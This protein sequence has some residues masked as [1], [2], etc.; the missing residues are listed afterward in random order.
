[1]ISK[2]ARLLDLLADGELDG[3][4][5][6]D[7]YLQKH[8]RRLAFRTIYRALD[9]M[10]EDGLA[11]SRMSARP[12]D[13]GTRSKHYASVERMFVPNDQA[14]YQV[15]C[16]LCEKRDRAYIR[17]FP[18]DLP[19]PNTTE[20]VWCQRLERDGQTEWRGSCSGCGRGFLLT[21]RPLAHSVES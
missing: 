10:V 16:H 2:Q 8:G 5:I 14:G 6:R 4:E 15:F 20:M 13:W 21:L 7:A 1:M 19:A 9:C 12:N 11:V 18:H 3:V 17:P